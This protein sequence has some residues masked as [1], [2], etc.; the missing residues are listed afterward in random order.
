MAG[1]LA[2]KTSEYALSILKPGITTDEIDKKV[3]EFIIKNGAYPTAIGF[4]NF[5]KSL[6]T[7][8]NEGGI[9]YN[10]SF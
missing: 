5:P 3:H 1:S 4:M 6:C 7:S 8:V 10:I 2:A 9:L